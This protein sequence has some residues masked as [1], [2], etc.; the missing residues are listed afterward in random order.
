MT[1]A[2][3]FSGSTSRRHRFTLSGR[4]NSLWT[5]GYVGTAYGGNNLLGQWLNYTASGYGGNSLLRQRDPRHF[6]FSILQRVSPDMH[7]DD[8]IQLEGTWKGRLHARQ[9]YGL[10]EN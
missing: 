3:L 1:L 8:V 4:A 5:G 10:N 2:H 6:R 9:P 7:A